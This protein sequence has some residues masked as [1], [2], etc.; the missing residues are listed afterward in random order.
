MASTP[1]P[2]SS[3]AKLDSLSSCIEKV[4]GGLPREALLA[5]ARKLK[6]LGVGA[7]GEIEVLETVTVTASLPA[8]S[9]LAVEQPLDG[10]ASPRRW[11]GRARW[12]SCDC[13]MRRRTHVEPEEDYGRLDRRERLY[14]IVCQTI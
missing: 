5:A 14:Y 10:D 1:Y 9:E 4:G 2:Q 12:W 6:D 13:Q 3:G 7:D 11:G 8:A